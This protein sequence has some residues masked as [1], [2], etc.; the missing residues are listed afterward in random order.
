MTAFS[1]A[2]STT[3]SLLRT[4]CS[5]L[6]ISG[7]SKGGTWLLGVKRNTQPSGGPQTGPSLNHDLSF[8]FLPVAAKKSPTSRIEVSASLLISAWTTAALSPNGAKIMRSTWIGSVQ[9]P[10][11]V[12]HQS[13]RSS[14]MICWGLVLTSS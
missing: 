13:S 7:S 10:V 11:F 9:K 6:R 4:Y 8:G 5:A 1:I 12:P 14:K 3:W 2:S